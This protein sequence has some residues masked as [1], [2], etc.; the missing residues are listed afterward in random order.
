MSFETGLC[1]DRD[2]EEEFLA[3]DLLPDRES[4]GELASEARIDGSLDTFPAPGSDDSVFESDVEVAAPPSPPSPSSRAPRPPPATGG[5]GAAQDRTR[6]P[7][8]GQAWSLRDH[9][10]RGD[11]RDGR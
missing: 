5:G 8:R 3:Q 9:A 10:S 1:S 11:A 6:V 7:G 2:T 4:D